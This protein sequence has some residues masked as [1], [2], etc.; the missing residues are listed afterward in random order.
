MEDDYSWLNM[1][2]DNFRKPSL[3][4]DMD[5]DMDNEYR[6]PYEIQKY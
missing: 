6:K 5:M 4:M 1:L 3:D 2:L